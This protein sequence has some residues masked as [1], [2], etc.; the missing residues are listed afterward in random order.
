MVDDLCR[1][2]TQ[3]VLEDCRWAFKVDEKCLKA[4]VLEGKAYVGLKQYDKAVECYEK[5]K[6]IDARKECV[7]NEYIDRARIRQA[8]EQ[9]ER[10]A[11]QTF[12][13]SNETGLASVLGKLKR[14]GQLTIYYIGGL[15]VVRQKLCSDPVA[16]TLFR[17]SGGFELAD[18]HCEISRCLNTEPTSLSSSDVQ[19]A[20]GYV[21]VLQN[22]SVD[23]D[24]NQCHVL[25]M[26]HLPQQLMKLIGCLPDVPG[27]HDVA[28]AGVDL[29][30]YLTQTAARNR[31]QIVQRYDAVKLITVAFLLAARLPGSDIAV[32]AQRIIC[33]IAM[34]D[35]LRRQL[36][37]DFEQTVLA[38]FISLIGGESVTDRAGLSVKTMM[39]LSGD[40]W[41]RRR[42]T[43]SENTWSAC[44]SALTRLHQTNT[45][46]ELMYTLVTLLANMAV[47][48]TGAASHQHVVQLCATC[49]DLLTQFTAGGDSSQLVDACYLLLS[50]VLRVAPSS[51]CVECVVSKRQ[52]ISAA[53]RDLR[54]VLHHHQ[55]Q[56]QR[57][58][59][60]RLVEGGGDVCSASDIVNHCVAAL[61]ACTLTSDQARHQLTDV[62]P[63][64]IAL[65]ADLLLNSAERQYDQ[66][67][68]G[69]T[70]LCLSHCAHLPSAMTQLTAAA[71]NTDVIMTLLVL[72]RDHA[73]PAVQHNCAILIAKLVSQHEPF[74]DRLR[75]LHG[76]EILHTVLTHV[77]P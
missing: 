12:E 74:L 31:S 4:A 8:A 45:N 25:A 58:G 9:A 21:K 44:I 70:A 50:R 18:S 62:T 7:I 59:V 36:R 69:N 68:I 57:A 24:E 5:A 64:L 3:G 2:C 56:Q 20:T 11:V 71:R 49:A 46:T 13:A 38:S 41:L 51:D 47:S 28:A 54:H 30:L 10:S 66:V 34:T 73:K 6:K 65:L 48:G 75:Q 26:P 55:Q 40:E 29:L 43:D 63:S 72:A 19:L 67:L 77:K 37:E 1:L 14:P 39:N 33:N 22:A 61:T 35:R 27:C 16:R 52:L 60:R 53:S 15:E 17:S 23:N 32:N 42:M 76:L